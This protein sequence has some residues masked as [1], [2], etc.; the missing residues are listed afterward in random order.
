M[1]RILIISGKGGAGKSMLAS[2]LISFLYEKRRVIGIDA[3]VDAPDLAVWLNLN[4][5]EVK[6][7]IYEAKRVKIKNQPKDKPKA[8]DLCP[9]KAIRWSN[10]EI[11][12]LHYLCEGCGLCSIINPEIFEMVEV[13]NGE[14]RE[15]KGKYKVIE[16]HLLP[17]FTGSG[18]IVTDLIKFSE[19]YNYE[20]MIIDGAP[21]TGCPVNAALREADKVIF[22]V[23]ET[24]NGVH[25]FYRTLEVV[26]HF[27]KPYWLV[28]NKHGLNESLYKKL[29]EEHNVLGTI[30]YS[31]EVF[32]CVLKRINVF[33][34]KEELIKN[35]LE[36]IYAEVIN[37]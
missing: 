6:K 1:D 2:A 33:E 17:G 18:K 24:M 23:E 12:Y 19:G 8:V 5:F 37:Q 20:I 9:H 14:I 32:K 22:V 3:D 31:M 30:P 7:E 11:K 28:I 10:G 25:D 36:R 15:Y 4:R 26:K 21:G 34:C 29:V 16:G 27:N 13:K 35:V